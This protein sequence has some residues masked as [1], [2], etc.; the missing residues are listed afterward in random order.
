MP[1]T[2]SGKID[3]LSL[4]EPDLSRSRGGSRAGMTADERR[5]AAIWEE[6]LGVPDIGADEDFFI[7][8][9]DSLLAIRIQHRVEAD[10][11]V[12]IPV[13][14]FIQAAT[15]AEQAKLVA[16][17]KE[18]PLLGRRLISLRKEGSRPPLFLVPP[19]GSTVLVFQRLVQHLDPDQPVYGLQPWGTDGEMRPHYSLRKMAADYIREMRTISPEGPYLIGG[20]CFG[21]I[22]VYEM[23]RQLE[24]MRRPAGLVIILDTIFPPNMP[25]RERLR[26]LVRLGKKALAGKSYIPSAIL[27][28]LQGQT[29]L[30]GMEQEEMGDINRVF[31]A[32]ALARYLY[33]GAPYRGKLHLFYSDAGRGYGW[34]DRWKAIADEVEMQSMPGAHSVNDSFL[35][36][37][38]VGALAERLEELI[39]R[40]VSATQG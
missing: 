1:L 27:T 2:R 7:L 34:R 35:R 21:G 31:Q 36:E 30:G 25:L 9:G 37:P 38:N 13:A 14:T 39:R 28:R 32:N 8:G 19:A 23:A 33:P 5:L 29:A 24:R 3:R 17:A 16:E 11:D 40:S 10:F 12:R 20:M 6:V 4:P 18:G 22:V 26:G 15:V